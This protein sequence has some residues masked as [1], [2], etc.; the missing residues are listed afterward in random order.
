MTLSG[1]LREAAGAA[2]WKAK[3]VERVRGRYWMVDPDVYLS[4][5]IGLNSVH[6]VGGPDV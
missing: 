5:T 3:R 2:G 4:L 1:Y 6:R